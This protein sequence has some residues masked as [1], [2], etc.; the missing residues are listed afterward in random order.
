MNIT[1]Y[2]DDLCIYAKELEISEVLI[3]VSSFQI[4]IATIY[5]HLLVQEMVVC[6]SLIVIL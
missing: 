1:I 3:I 2:E 6:N 4:P 5:S